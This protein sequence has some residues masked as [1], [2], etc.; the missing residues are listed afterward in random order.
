MKPSA[1]WWYTAKDAAFA[2]PPRRPRIAANAGSAVPSGRR[3]PCPPEAGTAAGSSSGG[4]TSTWGWPRPAPCP[5][6]RATY[7]SLRFGS[8]VGASEF[9]AT[10][11]QRSAA[12]Q[13]LKRRRHLGDDAASGRCIRA[14]ARRA[15]YLDSE[16]KPERQHHAPPSS[17]STLTVMPAPDSCCARASISKEQLDNDAVTLECANGTVRPRTRRPPRRHRR[18]LPGLP[19]ESVG[20]S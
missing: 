2:S 11:A 15:V 4:S 17:G 13:A 14:R 18:V 10:L 20:N 19:I 3:S 12:P 16:V 7:R 9:H 6:R 5:E 1:S 8:F